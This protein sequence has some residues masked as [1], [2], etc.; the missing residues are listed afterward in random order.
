MDITQFSQFTV[1]MKF[2]FININERMDKL[3]SRVKRFCCKTL[4]RYNILQASLKLLTAPM[5]A[6]LLLDQDL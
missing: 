3:A 2:K 1:K 5:L 6:S 4:H